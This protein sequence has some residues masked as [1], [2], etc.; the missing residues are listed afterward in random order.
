MALNGHDFGLGQCGW[1]NTEPEGDGSACQNYGEVTV[2]R[3]FATSPLPTSAGFCLE[4]VGP[5]T[6]KLIP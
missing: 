6:D 4:H 5:G 1:I 3:W 2:R